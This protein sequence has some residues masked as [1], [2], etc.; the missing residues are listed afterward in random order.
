MNMNALPAKPLMLCAQHKA[1]GA[2]KQ[3]DRPKHWFYAVFRHDRVKFAQVNS[4]G[5]YEAKRL[6]LVTH[7][8]N[9][10]NAVRL[11][12]RELAK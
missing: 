5:W 2:T 1:R 11:F 9:D 8:Y 6:V 10:S 3:A 12:E 4:H 7:P